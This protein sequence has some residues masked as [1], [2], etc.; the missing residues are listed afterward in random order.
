MAQALQEGPRTVPEVA[1][2]T[3]LPPHQVLWHIMSMK[4]YGK[5]V[6]VEEEDG[7]LR[8][9]LKEKES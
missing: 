6:E 4:K 2:A 5:V 7:Y 3:G 1:R 8:Y 9:G